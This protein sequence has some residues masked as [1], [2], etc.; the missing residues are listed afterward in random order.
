MIEF[1]PMDL[2]WV[3]LLILILVRL[4]MGFQ[5]QSVASVSSQLVDEFGF[6]YAEVGALIG[7][8]LLP[9]IVFAIPVGMTTRFIADKTLLMI[10]AALMRLGA[11]VMGLASD[12]SLLYGGRLLT[13]VGRTSLARRRPAGHRDLGDLRIA[14]AA[15][16]MA[17]RGR[18][19]ACRPV[20]D[21]RLRPV[22]RLALPPREFSRNPPFR[23]TPALSHRRGCLVADD[24]IDFEKAANSHWLQLFQMGLLVCVE[25]NP[26]HVIKGSWPIAPVWSLSVSAGA[27][28]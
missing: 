18:C 2:R 4:A 10:G 7:F 28:I 1:G 20:H 25:I 26:Q 24:S 22:D 8:F 9:G 13:G 3:M 11:W 16:S 6:S 15:E 17:D 21:T 19:R 5:F 23:N 14:S 12:A 27:G